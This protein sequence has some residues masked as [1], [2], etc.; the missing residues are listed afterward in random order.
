MADGGAPVAGRRGTSFKVRA[1]RP[2]MPFAA[3]A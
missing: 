1:V 2:F 3:R